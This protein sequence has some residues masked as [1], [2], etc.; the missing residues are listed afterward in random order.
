MF[1]LSH[2]CRLLSFFLLPFSFRDRLSLYSSG[3][4]ETRRATCLYLLRAEVKGV[5]HLCQLLSA[6]CLR[7]IKAALLGEIGNYKWQSPHLSSLL[8]PLLFLG[9]LFHQPLPQCL[10]SFPVQ[11]HPPP[12]WFQL[13]TLCHIYLFGVCKSLLPREAL[14]TNV[15][16]PL[17]QKREHFLQ[18][19]SS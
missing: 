11:C 1:W 19:L 15:V 9:K 3:W 13:C 5:L 14:C 8:L 17:P 16:G 10:Y 18:N 7:P 6:T 12:G 4:S 2:S